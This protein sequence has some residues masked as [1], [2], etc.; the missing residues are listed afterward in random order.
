[1]GVD[2]KI[3]LPGN[4]RVKDVAKI[5]AILDGCKVSKYEHESGAYW[6][7]VETVKV[8]G[9]DNL[10]ECAR[11]TWEGATG[12]RFV[13]YHFEPDEGNG[14]LLMPPSTSWWIAA[15][16]FL[17]DFYGGSADFN[18][19]DDCAVDYARSKEALHCDRGGH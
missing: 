6:A 11:I 15:A 14:R 5:L 19:C 13:L 12:K 1:M 4:A 18:D 2:C 17:V 8:A 3:H 9:I 10:P 16:K 7:D